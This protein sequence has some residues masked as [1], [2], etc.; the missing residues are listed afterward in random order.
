[1]YW[2]DMY[3]RAASKRGDYYDLGGELTQELVDTVPKGAQL[4][5]WDYYH[6]NEEF[7]YEMIKRHRMFGSDPIFAGGIWTWTGYTANWGKTFNNTNPAL[8][9]CKKEGIK[10]VFVTIWGDNGTEG[11]V[12]M[13]LL[14][15]QLYAEHGYAKELDLQKL[16]ERF[17][18]CTG[19]NYDDFISI[20]Y[21]DEVPGVEKD[22]PREC[23]PSKYLM[24]QDILTGLIDYHIKGL[25]LQ[26]H[27]EK[28]TAVLDAARSRNGE[29][30]H[31]FELL[32]DVSNVLA[33]KA[34]A[35]VRI[36]KAYREG[37]KETLRKY[38]EEL[39]P[40]L[41]KRVIVLR[42]THKK[43]WFANNKPLG[44][45]VL[46]MRYGSLLVRIESAIEQIGDYLNGTLDRLEELE[47]ERLPFKPT[48]G[49]I[50]YAN[51]Y[52]A[53]VSPSRIAPRA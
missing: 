15:L 49:L 52:D 22:N 25:P 6:D 28:M 3:F 12:F 33:I 1:M 47:Q 39:L 2:S 20:K 34:E 41:K 18:F 26:E 21:L 35:G 32:Y 9:A 51:F 37:D 38:A 27:Y 17:E 19:C 29:Y 44:W 7:Y 45:D 10:E 43:V 11:D 16:K 31:I 23:N 30:N 50:S 36:T 46:D 14:G 42:K 8:S 53:V 5:Y 4:V 40:E 48:E 13:N 24:W